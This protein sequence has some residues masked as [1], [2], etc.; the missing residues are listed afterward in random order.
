MDQPHVFDNL[1]L[2]LFTA[3]H[4]ACSIITS[5][6]LPPIRHRSIEGE[7]AAP[8]IHMYNGAFLI[9]PIRHSAKYAFKLFV[10][11]RHDFVAFVRVDRA[12]FA[13]LFGEM[14]RIDQATLWRKRKQLGIR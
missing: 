1:K 9:A 14:E 2:R 3:P 8:P 6:T 10:G 13:E 5:G 12:D 4:F 11:L 7:H